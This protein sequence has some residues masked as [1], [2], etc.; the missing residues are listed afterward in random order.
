MSGRKLAI[1]RAAFAEL[2]FHLQLAAVAF[3]DVL[4]D[5]E[6]KAGAAAHPGS[7]EIDTI[8]SLGEPGQ[9]F[10]RD[11]EPV[12]GDRELRGGADFFPGDLDDAAIRTV[13]DGVV[14]EVRAGAVQLA[15]DTQDAQ[16][17]VT[18]HGTAQ[19]RELPLERDVPGKENGKQAGQAQ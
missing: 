18:L 13:A 10:G 2:A 9:V 1:E 15:F 16:V 14:Q 6:P 12:I 19:S 5:G 8:E 7:R 11:A 3:E 4:D 17:A